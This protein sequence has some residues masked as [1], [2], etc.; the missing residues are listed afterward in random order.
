MIDINRIKPIINELE[1]IWLNLPDQRF[2]QFISNII[3]DIAHNNNIS[4][5]WFPEDNAWLEYLKTYN[6]TLEKGEI[7]E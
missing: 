5:I 2:G 1:K 3:G 7:N 6:N 4:D